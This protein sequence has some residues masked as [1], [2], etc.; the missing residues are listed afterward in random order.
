VTDSACQCSKRRYFH[1]VFSEVLFSPHC[2]IERSSISCLHV[3]PYSIVVSW[4]R[5]RREEKW[6][7]QCWHTCSD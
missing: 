4:P 6:T 3:W 2:F 5:N 1:H 7:K